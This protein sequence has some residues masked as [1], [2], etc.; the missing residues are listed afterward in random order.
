MGDRSHPQGIR[1]LEGEVRI[2]G[3]AG[4]IGD[5]VS[6]GD[7][8][9]TGPRSMAVFVVGRAVFLIREESR[10]ELTAQRLDGDR[11]RGKAALKTLR[12]LNGK[13]LSVFGEGEEPTVETPTLIAGVRGTGFYIE[14]DPRRSYICTCYGTIEIIARKAPEHRQTVTAHHHEMARYV[15][16]PGAEVIIEEAPMRNHTDAELILLESMVGRKPPFVGD[17]TVPHRKKRGRNGY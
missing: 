17:E 11:D 1:K 8:V 10:L 5:P 4:K 12:L 9:T 16:A 7:V 2:N 6:P 14:A 15:H 3:V 13:L